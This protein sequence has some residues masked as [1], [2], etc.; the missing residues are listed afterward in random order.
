M[1]DCFREFIDLLQEINRTFDR[2]N[3]DPGRRKQSGDAL[4][5]CRVNA[6]RALL[7]AVEV[8]SKVCTSQLLHYSRR[9]P[10]QPRKT[11]VDAVQKASME[12]LEAIVRGDDHAQLS[13]LGDNLRRAVF[14][15]VKHKIE[16][17]VLS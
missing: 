6:L 11:D 4:L 16:S 15:G 14:V 10:N 5:D 8:V 9:F 1:S 13:V 12:I 3:D 7:E 17:E 2:L